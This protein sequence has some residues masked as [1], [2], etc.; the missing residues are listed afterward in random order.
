MFTLIIKKLFIIRAK[1]LL[2]CRLN[3]KTTKLCI[4]V[5]FLRRIDILEMLIN[6]FSKLF[7]LCRVVDKS[8]L[9]LHGYKI[10]LWLLQVHHLI[11][12]GIKPL[13]YVKELLG[14]LS[15]LIQKVSHCYLHI[16]VVFLDINIFNWALPGQFWVVF[17]L[18]YV[19]IGRW[20]WDLNW[21]IFLGSMALIQTCLGFFMKCNFI[22]TVN[23]IR[24]GWAVRCLSLTWRNMLCLIF[25][26]IGMILNIFGFLR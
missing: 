3:A 19:V 18:S 8:K 2:L 24:V 25:R 6:L 14:T 16:S 4:L 23:S 11:A 20:P 12:F 7:V 21:G 13:H 26:W 10:W 9:I 22:N 5:V 17:D 1:F 15:V